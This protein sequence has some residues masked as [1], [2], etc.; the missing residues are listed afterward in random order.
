MLTPPRVGWEK[1]MAITL[2]IEGMTCMNCVGH[3]KKALLAV[4]GVEAVEVDL[5]PGQA[6]VQG[7]ADPQALIAAVEAEGYTAQVG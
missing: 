3:A 7:S 1:A 2:N 4:P 5:K 6:R